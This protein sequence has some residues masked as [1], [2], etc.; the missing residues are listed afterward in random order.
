MKTAPGTLPRR[1]LCFVLSVSSRQ[2]AVARSLRTV[3]TL[4]TT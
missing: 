2:A 4:S 3:M 1:G